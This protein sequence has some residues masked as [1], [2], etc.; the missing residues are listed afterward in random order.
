MIWKTHRSL[1]FHILHLYSVLFHSREYFPR[2]C[3]HIYICLVK[4]LKGVKWGLYLIPFSCSTIY[5]TTYFNK[6]FRIIIS[7]GSLQIGCKHGLKRI[8]HFILLVLTFSPFE[9]F[10]FLNLILCCW[11]TQIKRPS[12]LKMYKEAWNLVY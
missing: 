3:P 10:F 6:V 1:K 11:Q 8:R 5:S 4:S 12:L 9:R 7:Q 2:A